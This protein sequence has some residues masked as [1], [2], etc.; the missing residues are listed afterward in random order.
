MK[1]KLLLNFLLGLFVIGGVFSM[2]KINA[3][4]VDDTGLFDSI[5]AGSTDTI[6]Y[7]STVFYDVDTD[8]NFDAAFVL[9]AGPIG[10]WGDYST[11]VAFYDEGFQVRNGGSMVN[12]KVIKPEVGIAADVWV[13]VDV[14]SQTY[15]AWI[16]TSTMEY[17]ALI[18]PDAGFRRTPVDSIVRWSA[19]HNPD[20]EPD[21]LDVLNVEMAA[22]IPGLDVSTL[23]ALTIDYGTLDPAFDPG[24]TSYDVLLPYGT[25]GDVNVTATATTLDAFVSGDGAIDVTTGSAKDTITVISFDLSDTTHYFINFTVDDGST[26]AY[27]D[28]IIVDT[29][30]LD[31]VFDMLTYAYTVYVPVGTG[32]VDVSAT[33]NYAGATVVG[34]STLDIE[35]GS[36]STDIVVTAQDGVTTRT[37]TVDVIEADGKNYG[38]YLPG[39]SGATSNVDISGL[40]ITSYPITVEFWMKAEGNQVNNTG[41]F[42]HR[43]EGSD[44][45]GIQYSS[46]WQGAG[47]LRVMTNIGGDYGVLSPVISTDI[48]HHV[49]MVITDT[50]RIVHLDSIPYY[51]RKDNPA[52]DFSVGSLYLGWD[53][54]AGDRAFKGII[55]EVR[56]WSVLKDSADLVDHKYDLLNGDEANLVA[57]YNF[58]LTSPTVAVDLTDNELHGA[59]TGGDYVLTFDPSDTTLSALDVDIGALDPVFDP[60]VTE[61]TVIFP[62]GTASINV[63]ALPTNL[64]ASVAGVG[65]VDVSSGSGTANV[66]VTAQNGV[67]QETYTIDFVEADGT[68]YAMYLQ[69][70][71]GNTSHIDISG[72]AV[73]TLPYTIEMW[74]KPE[75]AQPNNAG[76][77]YHRAGGNAGIQYSSSWQGSGKLRFMT[78]IDGDYGT[79]TDVI[80]TDA[81]H[82]VAAVLTDTTRTLYV[83]G[84][85]YTMKINSSDYNYADGKLYLGWDAGATDRAFKGTIEDVRFWNVALD[86]ATIADNRLET[87]AGDEPGLAG[88][89]NFDLPNASQAVDLTGNG[90][91]G[92]IAGGTYVEFKPEVALSVTDTIYIEKDYGAFPLFVSS[93]NIADSVNLLPST[94]FSVTPDMVK[95]PDLLGGM[96]VEV[97]ATTA[98]VGDIGNL[99]VSYTEDGITYPVDTVAIKVIEPYQRYYIYQLASGRVIGSRV[100]DV[101]IP[102]LA[103]K[104]AGDSSQLF[105]LRPV[106]PGSD[107]VY[108]VEDAGG[109]YFSKLASSGWNTILGPL[110]QGEWKLVY[111]TDKVFRLQNMFN[112]LYLAS[113]ATAADSRLYADK[114][115]D[116]ERGQFRLIRV[117]ASTESSL[118]GITVDVGTLDPT[119]ASGTLEYA[120][121]VPYGTATVNVAATPTDANA[122]VTGVGDIDVSGGSGTATIEVVSED[123]SDTTTYTVAIS[124]TPP[125]TDAKLSALTVDA[126]TLTPVF[127]P[128]STSYT[129]DD[130]PEGT[131]SVT[132]TATANDPNAD[133]TG[134][135][136]VDVSSGS[137]TATIVVTAEDG[138]TTETYTVELTVLVGIQDL[139]ASFA[140][141]YPT[142]SGEWFNIRFAGTP[143]TI[144][145]FD[146]TGQVILKRVATNSV[147]T[148]S[149]PQSGIYLMKIE[150]ELNSKV[151]KVV[152]VQ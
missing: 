71:D 136:A 129:V 18:F 51:E 95:A 115:A 124:V 47:R 90:V 82:H 137:G 69:G 102:V 59:I 57:Y 31:P 117:D 30:A 134:A 75:G 25:T 12:S 150:N 33:A 86:S 80:S 87:L 147:E 84:V 105:S 73:D 11:A 108:I 63:S 34:D 128:D 41:M 13:D 35:G 21:T 109:R 64:N 146:L 44:N 19:V 94:G 37:Y 62:I 23:S 112:D 83:D 106:E 60:A 121:V 14:G 22:S 133:V 46:G 92:L 40:P 15:N 152:V 149:I 39:S 135:A 140:T 17:P 2:A 148:L 6:V 89:W 68:N 101:T 107:V 55:D 56:I 16:K 38:M 98:A 144:T 72:L 65:A 76:L 24:M 110:D 29:S 28:T 42:Y 88:Y 5:K 43:G 61:Y 132:V 141:V 1:N 52:Y 78:N 114:A 20:G 151:V 79:V 126:G 97:D 27:L 99:F 111:E 67:D 104:V 74:I 118:S 93:G 120:V 143:G 70:G 138:T 3:Q 145:V 139:D 45:A 48:W 123:L 91:H 26:D 32:S 58:N 49:A 113:D 8:N 119:F 130:V 66:V 131:L 77:I 125:A 54:G 10:T 100:S 81:W 36:A 9:S 142:I 127:H 53:S 4:T 50:S 122:D 103:D 7:A 116:H 96:T 85:K